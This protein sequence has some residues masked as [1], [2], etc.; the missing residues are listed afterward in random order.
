[1]GEI[2]ECTDIHL[3]RQVIIKRLQPGVEQRRIVDEQKA[4]AALRSKH[5]VQLFDIIELTDRGPKELGLVLEKING[6]PITPGAYKA[7][8]ASLAVLWQIAC[9]LADIHARG[10]VHRD[11][12]PGNILI[13]GEGVVKIIDFGLARSMGMDAKT[14]SVIGTPLFMAPE[15]WQGGAISFD[16]KIDV[17]AFG[18]TALA[19]VDTTPPTELIARPPLPVGGATLSKSFAGY[20]AP[21]INLL[22]SCFAS[23]AAK[24][25]KMS[26]V[27]DAISRHLLKD[28]HR[29]TVVLNGTPNFLNSKNRAIKLN[30]AGVGSL[31]IEY[32]GL[33]F[34]VTAVSGNVF[35]N[36]TSIVTGNVLPGCCVI[37]FGVDRNRRF[38]TFDVS[39]PEVM[40]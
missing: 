23:D 1:M 25:P 32:D 17:Y 37:T 38:V 8:K 30:A 39:S 2:I 16:E 12:K 26:V 15:L 28:Q 40:P 36:N 3:E 18:V 21:L 10:I 5:V 33:D 29:A 13:D 19:L 11:V 9:G 24:R 35:L 34:R 31:A 22:T 14:H 6:K 4:L 7:D 20:P 27:A